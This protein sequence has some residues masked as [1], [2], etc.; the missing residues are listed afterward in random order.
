[1]TRPKLAHWSVRAAA[2]ILED[3]NAPALFGPIDNA[4]NVG[5]GPGS[6]AVG[7]FNGDGKPDLV[8]ASLGS[9]VLTVLLGNASGGFS[10]P[11]GPP[12]PAGSFLTFVAVGD[13]NGDGRQ[14]LAV[15]NA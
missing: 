14:D 8:T 1:M 5:G 15:A 4:V 7:D 3:R 11:P 2:E 12:P 6:V 13:F 9:G 10:S